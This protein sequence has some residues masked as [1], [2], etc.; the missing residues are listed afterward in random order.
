MAASLQNPAESSNGALVSLVLFGSL[1]TL[2]TSRDCF[3]P[4]IYL[5]VVFSLMAGIQNSPIQPGQGK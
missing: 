1:F 5:F 4:V 2:E 3:I